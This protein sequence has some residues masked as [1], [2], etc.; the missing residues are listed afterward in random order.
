MKSKYLS[1]TILL[2]LLAGFLPEAQY[3][4]SK[5]VLQIKIDQDLREYIVYTP[6]G[7]D[8]K[9]AYPLVFMLHGGSG[10]GEKFY[11]ISGWNDLAD[12]EEL[13]IVYP[14]SW[15]YDVTINGCGNNKTTRWHNLGV[16]REICNPNL[17]RDDV[18]F[19]AGM[20]DEVSANFP[21]NTDRIYVSGFSNGGGMAFRIASELSD[22]V[23][24]VAMHASGFPL[25]TV[26]NPVRNTPMQYFLGTTDK[27]VLSA[28]SYQASLPF[29][30]D[31]L[32]QEPFFQSMVN[33]FTQSFDLDPAYTLTR[34]KGRYKTVTFAGNSGA[35]DHL[36]KYTLID[37]LGHKFPNPPKRKGMA[38][39]FWAFLKQY[40]L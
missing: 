37:G 38:E 14:T 36:F 17:L 30:H 35:K 1:L 39:A 8:P 26:L 21:V 20:M 9:G 40:E 11:N 10:T 33:T 4:G 28:S 5:Q 13:I 32:F 22:R 2:F 19:L 31:S 27:K 3:S 34:A 24:A 25:D 16:K 23:A 29:D 18:K 7:L 15:K 12:Q 6:A